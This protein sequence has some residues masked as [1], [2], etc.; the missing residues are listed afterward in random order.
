LKRR[1]AAKK[2]DRRIGLLSEV[3]NGIKI[4][5]MYCWETPFKQIIENIRKKEIKYQGLF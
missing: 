2:C 4:I 5:K 1:I 3:L